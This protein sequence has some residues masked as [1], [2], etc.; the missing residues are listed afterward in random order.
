[1]RLY[2]T[3]II[4]D[5]QLEETETENQIKLIED[6][7]KR[8]G[9]EIVETQRWGTRRFAYEIKGKRQGNYTY[10]LYEGEPSIPASL[11]DAFKVNEKIVRYLTVVSEIDLE[12]KKAEIAARKPAPEPTPAPEK[13][14]DDAA[15]KYEDE[16]VD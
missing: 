14:E 6:L 11:Q 13:P 4:T 2:E 5:T 12:A 10:F 16:E 9:G 8:G 1:L 15:S 3:T 7:I